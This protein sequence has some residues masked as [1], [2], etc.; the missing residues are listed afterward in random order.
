MKPETIARTIVAAIALLNSV[1]IMIGKAPLD[2]DE[3]TIYVVV[4]G[5]ATIVTTIWVY[6]KNNDITPEA[7]IGSDYMR[8]LKARRGMEA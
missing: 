3:N 5:I 1:L 7:M 6:W 4:S 8:E 2:L